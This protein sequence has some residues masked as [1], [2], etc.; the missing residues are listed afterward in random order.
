MFIVN[1]FLKLIFLSSNSTVVGCSVH[2]VNGWYMMDSNASFDA[3]S[4]S[5]VKSNEPRRGNGTSSLTG[6]IVIGD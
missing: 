3:R 2:L 4:F 6:L 5:S 1:A